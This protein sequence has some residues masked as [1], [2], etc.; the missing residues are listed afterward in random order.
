[1]LSAP[2]IAGKSFGR[3]IAL[4]PTGK[5]GL[6]ECACLCGKRRTAR[7]A[8]LVRGTVR[9]CGCL[10]RDMR[11]AENKAKIT[12]GEGARGKVT[13]EYSA[14][15][16]MNGRCNQPR[17]QLFEYYGKRGIKVCARWNPKLGG[18]YEAFLADMGRRLSSDHSID[19]IDTNGDYTPTNCRWATRTEQNNNTRANIWV[20]CDGQRATLTEWCRRLGIGYDSVWRRRR[21]GQTPEEALRNAIEAK[22]RRHQSSRTTKPHQE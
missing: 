2:N 6:W 7:G 20:E 19:R 13:P 16:A 17:H 12:H 10:T 21:Q 15:I 4:R 8:E 22:S 14:W 18:T 11:R 5:R 9:S 1:M 3:L